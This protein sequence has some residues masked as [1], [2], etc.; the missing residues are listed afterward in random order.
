[1]KK[2]DYNKR[3]ICTMQGHEPDESKIVHALTDRSYTKCLRCHQPFCIQI[4]KERMQN[5]YPSTI[6]EDACEEVEEEM[7][8]PWWRRRRVLSSKIVVF[9]FLFFIPFLG[10]ATVLTVNPS[11]DGR[12]YP[13]E[14]P[15]VS[16]STIRSANGDATADCCTSNAT[17]MGSF[18]VGASANTYST[19]ARGLFEFSLGDLPV[20]DVGEDL[21]IDSA[22]LRL[23]I[24]DILTSAGTYSIGITEGFI[25][26]SDVAA[27]DYQANL[28]TTRYASDISVSAMSEGSY[29]EWT[30][31]TAGKNAILTNNGGAITFAVRLAEDIDNGDPAATSGQF[32]I[33]AYL[34]EVSAGSKPELV[35]TYHLEAESSSSS[36]GSSSSSFSV[37]SATGSLANSTG[38]LITGESY[39]GEF[40]EFET[41]SG[42]TSW[43]CN[44]WVHTVKVPALR[45]FVDAMASVLFQIG[46]FFIVVYIMYK[47][48][49]I[50]IKYWWNLLN[51]QRQVLRRNRIRKQYSKSRNGFTYRTL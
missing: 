14:D 51:K 25:A 32:A 21:V 3:Q 10:H 28:S 27:S 45:F 43:M 16:W 7:Y 18:N 38:S 31:N 34:K 12:A 24:S 26:G 17:Y 47:W 40:E 37:P 33:E 46:T 23:K 6:F 29:T 13:D 20:P 49:I 48:G 42:T 11:I 9:F 50:I 5:L 8:I 44:V 41:G 4:E 1:M 30:L 22:V 39:C 15:A 35:I 36:A 19:Y 2:V